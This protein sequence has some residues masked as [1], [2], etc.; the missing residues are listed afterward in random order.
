M[1]ECEAAAEVTGVPDSLE[2]SDVA[3]SGSK[4]TATVAFSG[5]SLNE[6]AV[7]VAMRKE[8]GQWK[9]D[10]LLRFS[11]LDRPAVMRT[12]EK[13]FEGNGASAK[14]IKCIS[15]RLAPRSKKAFEA[16]LFE[17]D[18]QEIDKL[19]RPCT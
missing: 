12:L 1:E 8:E 14:E 4:A 11:K 15:G 18:Q 7:V 13:A 3:V 9:I 2:I 5:G 10:R 19:V 6:Q 16:F 17:S